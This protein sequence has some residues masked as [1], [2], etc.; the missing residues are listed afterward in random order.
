MLI[1][2]LQVLMDHGAKFDFFCDATDGET[3][4]DGRARNIGNSPFYNF[5]DVDDGYLLISFS[6]CL[7]YVWV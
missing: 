3:A 1:V 6:G 2:L 5:P 7:E 4:E